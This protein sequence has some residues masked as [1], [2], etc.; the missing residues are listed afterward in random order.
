MLAARHDAQFEPLCLGM[1]IEFVAQPFKERF[2]PAILHFNGNNAGTD[3]VDIQQGVQHAGN[4]VQRRA[5]P[6]HYLFGFPA[7]DDGF[8]MMVEQEKGLQWLAEVV[9]CGS[10][11]LGFRGSR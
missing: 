9:A 11:K 1:I 3:P 6:R 8:K 5:N 2:Q 10:Q 7:L 4:R